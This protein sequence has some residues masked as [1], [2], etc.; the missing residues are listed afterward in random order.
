MPMKQFSKLRIN[1]DSQI[2]KKCCW[3]FT[4]ILQN[5]EISVNTSI[6]LVV[7]SYLQ[8]I[9]FCYNRSNQLLAT[10]DVLDS[11]LSLGEYLLVFPMVQSSFNLYT[12]IPLYLISIIITLLIILGV[13]NI[14]YPPTSERLQQEIK[15]FLG[16]F[17]EVVDKICFIPVL[18]ILLL[19]MKCTTDATDTSALQC[20]SSTYLL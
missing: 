11:F 10:N 15:Q 7:I 19:S 14:I 5:K 6:M 16:V 20:F 17:M 4:A 13:Y 8:L 18:G 9:F 12:F 1:S 3:L 2:R